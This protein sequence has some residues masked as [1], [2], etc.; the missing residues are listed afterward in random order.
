MDT[1]TIGTFDE[2]AAEILSY[3]IKGEQ[4]FVTNGEQKNIDI[5]SV[6]SPCQIMKVGEIDFSEHADGLQSVSVNNGLVA[7]AVERK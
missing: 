7:I 6:A 5:I 3:D 2:G 4:L 1:L